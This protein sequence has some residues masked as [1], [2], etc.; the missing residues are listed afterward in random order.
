MIPRKNEQAWWND[1]GEV[2]AVIREGGPCK[3]KH[4]DHVPVAITKDG[5]MWYADV[6]VDDLYSTEEEAYRAALSFLVKRTTFVL[7]TLENMEN[8]THGLPLPSA[9]KGKTCETQ[10]ETNLRLF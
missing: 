7:A 1:G 4:D 3:E 10:T 2:R 9:P 6:C 5:R 8:G